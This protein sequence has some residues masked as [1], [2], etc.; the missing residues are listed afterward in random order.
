VVGKHLAQYEI[1]ELLT[2]ETLRERLDAGAMPPRKVTE[3]GR[4]LYVQATQ[5]VPTPIDRLDTVT[6]ERTP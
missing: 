2:G 1:L 4:H 5:A 6:G 3:Y